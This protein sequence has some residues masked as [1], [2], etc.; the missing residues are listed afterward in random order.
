[1][2]HFFITIICVC[3]LTISGCNIY[4]K[5]KMQQLNNDRIEYVADSI[6]TVYQQKMDSIVITFENMTTDIYWNDYWE[7]S[8][9][10]TK[11]YHKY[12][13]INSFKQAKEILGYANN[14]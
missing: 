14:K 3:F 4:Y 11:V 9:Y 1:M 7:H 12:H 2:K 10:P 5:E 8:D 6:E 13:L